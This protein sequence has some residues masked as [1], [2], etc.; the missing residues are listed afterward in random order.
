MKPLKL[1]F[2][3]QVE[4]H[5]LY[6]RENPK[7][8]AERVHFTTT[9]PNWVDRL[10]ETRILFRVIAYDASGEVL[11][12]RGEHI[13]LTIDLGTVQPIAVVGRFI[14]FE[15][16]TNEIPRFYSIEIMVACL[17]LSEG[18]SLT[19]FGSYDMEWDFEVTNDGLF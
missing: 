18:E 9:D 7:V 19:L 10:I 13:P 16:I 3:P 4:G 14:S 15:F 5:L 12:E 17:P 1:E 8:F 2:L 6:I 11:Q